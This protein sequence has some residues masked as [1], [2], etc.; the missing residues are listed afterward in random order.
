ML[1]VLF[2]L[3]IIVMGVG[4]SVFSLATIY[5]VSAAQDPSHTPAPVKMSILR[6][7]LA[8][9]RMLPAEFR[10]GLSNSRERG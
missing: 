8:G 5:Q 3:L 4:S 10:Q 7:A 9:A 1:F 2:C 6:Q